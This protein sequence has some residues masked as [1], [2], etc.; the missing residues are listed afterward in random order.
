VTDPWAP[1]QPIRGRTPPPV[2][3]SG[4]SKAGFADRRK[5]VL[6]GVVKA[7]VEDVQFDEEVCGCV[8]PPP[9]GDQATLRRVRQ[10]VPG[11]RLL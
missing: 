3:V 2:Y 11:L 6:L 1:E 7:V 10:A 9:Q 8:G 5:G 4:C